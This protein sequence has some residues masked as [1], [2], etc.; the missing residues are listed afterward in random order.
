MYNGESGRDLKREFFGESK[1]ERGLSEF[2]V[3]RVAQNRAL[4]MQE[5]YGGDRTKN[6]LIND[7]LR[8]SLH[9]TTQK[10]MALEYGQSKKPV[11]FEQRGRDFLEDL[12]KLED[13][14][15]KVMLLSHLDLIEMQKIK[16]N[17]DSGDGA[18]AFLQLRTYSPKKI[19]LR[20]LRTAA[21]IVVLMPEG[22]KVLPLRI[23]TVFKERIKPLSQKKNLG[24]SPG[25]FYQKVVDMHRQP[26]KELKK[27]SRIRKHLE[28]ER[29][30]LFYSL[31]K[32]GNYDER[33]TI[34]SKIKEIDRRID[35]VDKDLRKYRERY[36]FL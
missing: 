7:Y 34:D 1:I 9:F 4:L 12:Q 26:N 27:L 33:K 24:T 14:G 13:S 11:L 20:L 3:Y 36:G 2:R 16:E 28:K 22:M 35:L 5:S 32:T 15:L 10:N 17:Q 21:E 19:S 25:Q 18:E 8:N 31:L 30:E 29:G 6:R 23:D